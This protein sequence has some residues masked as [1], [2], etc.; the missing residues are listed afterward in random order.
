MDLFEKSNIEK[1]NCSNFDDE[2]PYMLVNQD[3]NKN[4]CILFYADWCGYCN[5]LKPEYKNFADKALFIDVYALNID[6]N[7]NLL[8]KIK[9][10]DCQFK[11]TGYPTIWF[12]K[13]GVPLLEY[14]NDRNT[15]ELVKTAMQFVQE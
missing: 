10:S 1:I 6:E 11:I 8:E 12:Y 9:N 2:T 3:E 7:K 14:K 4:A 13:N 15:M 5:M